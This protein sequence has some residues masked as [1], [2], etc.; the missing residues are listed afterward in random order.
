MEL[1]EGNRRPADKQGLC[2]WKQGGVRMKQVRGREQ[3]FRG[4]NREVEERSAGEAEER[5][6]GREEGSPWG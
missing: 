6:A 5:S 4:R 1:A 3:G 2:G